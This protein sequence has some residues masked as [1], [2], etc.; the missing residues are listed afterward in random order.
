MVQRAVNGGSA[1]S[2]APDWFN[3]SQYIA[4]NKDL[5]RNF[6]AGGSLTGLGGTLEEAA[7]KHF[8]MTGQFEI[9]AGSRKY[10]SGTD[11]APGGWSLVGERGPELVRLTRGA[12]VISNSNLSKMGGGDE[13]TKALLRELIAEMRETKDA[14]AKTARVLNRVT[15]GGTSLK[16]TAA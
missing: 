13:E 6:N 3:V 9:A 10:A 8:L 4:D 12:Q 16:T 5:A 15:E 1:Y 11:S 7:L 14:T 2:A